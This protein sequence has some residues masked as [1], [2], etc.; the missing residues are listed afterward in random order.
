MLL[1]AWLGGMGTES[2]PGELGRLLRIEEVGGILQGT[3]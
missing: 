3:S 1:T 2:K